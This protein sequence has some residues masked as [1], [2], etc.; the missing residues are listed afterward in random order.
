MNTF[1]KHAEGKSLQDV[2]V[3]AYSKLRAHRDR[4][5]RNPS[6]F[7]LILHLVKQPVVML[8]FCVICGVLI[9]RT[10]FAPGVLPD[11]DLQWYQQLHIG[12]SCLISP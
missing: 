2:K 8:H 6:N 5:Q 4:S 3:S 11:D 12:L 9:R 1:R 7:Q 10:S